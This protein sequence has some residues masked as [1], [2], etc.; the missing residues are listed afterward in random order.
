[1]KFASTL[2]SPVLFLFFIS[3]SNLSIAQTNGEIACIPQETFTREGYG[4]T[5]YFLN[6]P[7]K[8]IRPEQVPDLKRSAKDI[9]TWAADNN[10]VGGHILDQK[11][12]K[13]G[14]TLDSEKRTLTLATD[15]D[16]GKTCY[17]DLSE[18]R[19]AKIK[20]FKDKCAAKPKCTLQED[21]P[22]CRRGDNVAPNPNFLWSMVDNPELGYRLTCSPYVSCS[23]TLKCVQKPAETY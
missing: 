15:R 1:M 14:D 8:E 3:W 6:S 2:A 7:Y 5:Y 11:T 18:R 9:C 4:Y 23:L 19:A 12:C 20:A 16:D 21:A 13:L 10:S 22:Q 17:D